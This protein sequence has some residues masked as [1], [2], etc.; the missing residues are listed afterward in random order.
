MHVAAE[1]QIDVVEVDGR[2]LPGG[3]TVGL[4]P[5]RERIASTPWIGIGRGLIGDGVVLDAASGNGHKVGPA[6]GEGDVVI[7]GDRAIAVAEVRIGI[8]T[9]FESYR[10]QRPA[11]IEGDATQQGGGGIAHIDRATD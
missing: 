2:R 7:D 10:I 6:G 4:E 3:E 8:E 1:L 11:V 5:M 9:V